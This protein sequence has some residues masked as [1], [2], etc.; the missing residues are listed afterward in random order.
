MGRNTTTERH[1]MQWTKQDGYFIEAR[2]E[3]IEPIYLPAYLCIL[4]TAK[5]KFIRS[6]RPFYKSIIYCN[7]DGF[8]STQEINLDL[9]NLRNTNHIVGNFRL[10]HRYNDLY[11]E[12]LNGYAGTTDDGKLI[13]TISGMRFERV[14]TPDQY[15]RKNFVYY[16]NEPTA[17]GTIRHKV[18]KIQNDV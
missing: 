18:I 3:N 17:N 7:T 16:V 8:L 13:N 12:C 15:E 5:S 9:L 11:L 6:I 1:T 4:D 2:E 10:C 14:L